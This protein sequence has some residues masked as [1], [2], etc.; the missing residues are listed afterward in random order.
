MKL[1]HPCLVF[2]LA[3]L[4]Q[5][6]IWSQEKTTRFILKDSLNVNLSL[7]NITDSLSIKTELHQ[8]GYFFYSSILSK[9]DSLNTYLITA[10]K[11]TN[12]IGVN[13]IPK[14][15]SKILKNNKTTAYIDSNRLSDW[16][17]NILIEF[18]HRGENFTQ[19]KLIN[20]KLINDTL[21]CDL[22][23]KSSSKR[24]I[25]KTV[26]KGYTRFA[27]RFLKHYIKSK[28]PFSKEI[29]EETENKI[30]QLNFVKNIRQPAVLFTKDSTHLYVYLDKI[31]ANR[32]DALIGFGN[33]EG[34]SKINFN[35]YIDISLT[36]VLHKGETLAFKWNN[37]GQD[38]QEIVLKIDNPYIFNS[39]I[40]ISYDLNIFRQDSTFVNTKQQ[41]GLN[42]KPHYKH[43]I[44]TYYHN[45]K[46]TTLTDAVNNNE[47]YNKNIIGFKYTYEEVNNWKIPKAKFELDIGYGIRKKNETLHYYFN[48]FYI[49]R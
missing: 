27:K 11:K 49:F 20:Q 2:Y 38:Q 17:D 48:S 19:I 30:N 34:E 21:Y 23:L 41:I 14:K 9:K 36:N 4:I 22:N 18:D 39:P 45:E 26:V 24:Y 44:G 15:V 8:H 29:L 10:G 37:S 7:E 43:N 3:L 35:G 16:I 46:S 31:K 12:V 1:Y 40:N 32:L 6:S 13:N 47:A 42:Y 28:K 25:N 33:Q 5:S